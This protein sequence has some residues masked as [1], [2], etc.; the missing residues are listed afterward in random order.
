MPAVETFAL[1]VA[2]RDIWLDQISHGDSPLYNIGA[3]VEL[4]GRVDVGQLQQALQHL[5]AEH[6]GLRTVLVTEGGLARQYF[7]AYMAVPLAWHDLRQASEPFAAALALLEAQM[8]TPYSLD[9]SPLWGATLIRV[10]DQRHLLAVQ[11][12]HL[13]LDGWGVDQWFKQLADYYQLQQQGLPLPRGAASYQAFIADDAQYQVSTRHARDR[14]YWL[15]SYQQLPDALSARRERTAPANGSPSGAQVQAFDSQLLARMRR[16]A[17]GL[18]ASP[19]HVLLAALHVCVTRTWQRDEWVVGLPVRNRGNARFKATLGLFTQVSALRMGFA[20][21]CSFAALVEGIRDALKQDY[22]HQRF[23]LSELNRSLGVLREERAQLFELMV[24]FEEDSNALQIADAP[25]HTVMICNGHEPT[26]L[27]IHLRCNSHSDAA[28]LHVVHN[29]A[30]FTDDEA[31]ALAGRLLHVL[32]QG[33]QQPQALPGQFDLLTGSEHAALEQWHATQMPV[34]DAGLIQQRIQAQAK[35]RPA[36]VAAL[37]NGQALTYGELERRAELLAQHLAGL[38]VRP[39]RR[40]ALIAQRGLDTLVG[41]LAVLKA[42]A[43]YVPIDPA[44]PRERLAY[45]LEDS[46]PDVLLTLSRLT[47]RLPAHGLRQVELDRF[48]WAATPAAAFRFA[49]Q[50]PSDLAYVIYTSGST[51]LP[52]G[53]MVEQHMLANLVDWHCSSFDLGPGRQQSSLAGFGFDAMAWEVWPALCSGATLHLAPV[54]DG[55]E[56]IDALLAWWRAQPLDVSFLPTPVAEHAF[57]QGELHP[58]L[59]T[60]LVGGDRLRRLARERRYRVINNYGPTETTVVA[61]SGQVVA[62]GPLH[63]GGPVA[64]TRLYVLDE[65]RQ[66]L[67]PGAVGELYVGGKGVARGYLNRPQMTAERFLHDPFNPQA[68]ARM[69]RTGDLVRW[70]PDGTLEYLGRNDDQVKIRGVRVELAEIEAA[71]VSHAAVRECVVMLRDG[72]LQAWFIGDPLVAT[73]A[74]HEHLRERLP[75]ALLPGAYVR[76][77]RWPLTANGKL[78]RRALPQAD[79]SAKVRREHEAPQGL[80]EQQL[81]QLWCELLRVERVGRQDHFFEL[82]GHSLLAVQLVERLRQQGLQAD[83]QVLFGQSTLASLAASVTQVDSPVVPENRVLPGCQHITPGMLALTELDQPAID[84]IVATVPGGAGNVQEIYPLAPLQQGLLYH[85]VTD[86]RDPYQ[87]QALFTFG[88]HEQLQAFIA[89]LQQ[90][91]ERHD[92]LRTSL[93]WEGLEHPQQVVWRQA[94]LPVEHWHGPAGQVRSHFDPQ[95]RPLDLRHAPMMALVCSEDAGQGRWLG[96]LRFHHLVNDAVSLQ[97]LLGEL[98]AFMA[99]Q[100]ERLPKPVAYRDYVAAST[101]AERQAGHAAFFSKQ[102]AGIE[103]QAPITGYGG[104][105]VDEQQLERHDHCLARERVVALRQQVRQQGASLASL[106]H[107]AWAQV[108]GTLGGRDEVVLGTVLL[109]RSMAGPGAGRAMGMFINSLPLRVTLAQRSAGQALSETHAGLAALLAHE[110]APLLLAQR[111]S[112]LPAG[113]ALFDSL[114]NYRQGSLPFG[115]VLPG[116]ELAEASEVHSYGL[117]L[118][119]DEQADTLQLAIR[120]PRAISAQRVMDYLLNALQQL[121]DALASRSS[122]GLQAMRT[123]PDGE[124]QRLLQEFNRTEDNHSPTWQTLPALFEA[125]ARRTPKAVALQAGDDS[126]DYETLNAQA[127]RLAHQLIAQGVGPDSR[128]AVCVER[129][130]ALMV[131]LLGVLKAGG[132]YVPLDPG[133]PQE[134]LRFMLQDC[135]PTL[136]LVHG[137]TQGLFAALPCRWLDLDDIGWQ[138]NPPDN[139]QVAGLGPLQLAY[140]MYTSGSTGTPKGVMVEHRGLCNLMHWGSQICPPRPGD[141]LLQRAP[142]TFDGSVWELFW[143]LTAGLRLVLARP[144]G[145]RDPAYMVQLIQTQQVSIVKFVPALLHQFLEQP[146]VERCTSLTDIFCGGGELTLALVHSVRKHL[147]NVRLHNVYGPTEATV[148]ST[149]WTLQAHAPLPTQAPPIGRPIANTRLYV[150]DAHD[151]PVPLGAVGQLHIGGVGVA[152]GYLGLPQLQAERFIASPFVEGDRLYRTGDLV[153]YRAD[154][155]LDFIGRND[156]QVKLRGVRVELG[157]IEALLATHPAVGQAVV[158]MRDERLVA[159]FTCSDGQQAPALEALRSHLLARMPEYMVP[160]AFVGLAALPLST[161]GKVDRKALPAPGAEAVI[162]REYQAPQGELETALAG[163]WTEV[164][165]IE[166]V[167]RDDN[168]FE[169]GGHSLLAVSLVARMRQAGLHVDAR[170]LF[171][172]PTLAGL[173]ASTQRE[174]VAVVVPPTTIPSLGKRRRL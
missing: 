51:G 20:R 61:T 84:R 71:L 98:E 15:A 107:L 157:E 59:Q 159:Y 169:L 12:H 60:L 174:Q 102:L 92:I 50:S 154:G 112:G 79:E 34:A 33:L 36:A 153:R 162:S 48:N 7:A 119:V 88:S 44:H 166:Q 125:Q 103:P 62:G 30:W 26:P 163:I 19:L 118:T 145:H 42:G 39:E 133:Y 129:S 63:I 126:L 52:K 101:Q 134:R 123:V 156:F 41:L 161:N 28:T 131:A 139:P 148:D 13:I 142:F 116:V 144:D 173:A 24:S 140:V 22:R 31:R 143:P 35:A 171:S 1:T 141:A 66:L 95:Q 67:P 155:D 122:A 138:A 4:Q 150:L 164:L 104:T 73:R 87:Q 96:L 81:A 167:G 76:L 137:A 70:L 27:S 109:G 64:N 23:A 128:V 74:L 83:I 14:D 29:R 57:A 90:V 11:A 49:P 121:G 55:T 99:G 2:Q 5:V 53:V 158:L 149:A 127:N 16:F 100:G 9:A 151:R 38:G 3:Y 43:A 25:G 172:Q 94:R 114:V 80:V 136:V 147:P 111:C 113:S 75:V 170:T 58:T 89:A 17:A 135:T 69:Y 47:E 65:Q 115:Q 77:E 97:V 108:L 45:L 152:R 132:A 8:R 105:T 91:I 110:D 46:A 130:V 160:Q 40:V 68:G 72:Q 78:D 37:H 6:D 165:K 56:D 86:A 32:E 10:A 85:H 93:C 146:G 21:E 82:G 117:V 18:Q 106:L 124:L 54:R 168:F 120:A